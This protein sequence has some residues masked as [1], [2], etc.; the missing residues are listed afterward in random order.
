V[1]RRRFITAL[2]VCAAVSFAMP[3]SSF[4]REN[5]EKPRQEDKHQG[6]KHKGGKHRDDGPNHK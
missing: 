2:A 4:A 6:G 5:S 1:I 3:A